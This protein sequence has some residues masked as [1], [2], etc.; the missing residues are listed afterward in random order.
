MF[1]S[2][3]KTNT[4]EA[5]RVIRTQMFTSWNGDR[6]DAANVIILITDG[7]SNNRDATLQEAVE[8]R[9]AGIHVIV[10]GVGQS[11]GT[12]EL[13]GIASDPDYENMYTVV[14]FY[15]LSGIM[16]SILVGTCNGRWQI[17]KQW[18]QSA[19]I[20]PTLALLVTP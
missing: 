6:P 8:T 19:F 7:K 13:A 14:N 2:T 15:A 1:L 20:M 17:S 4:A 5:L 18:K 9:K 10:I 3:G 12:Q 11:V 16:D